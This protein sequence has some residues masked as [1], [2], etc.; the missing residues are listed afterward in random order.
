MVFEKICPQQ[1]QRLIILCGGFHFSAFKWIHKLFLNPNE[2][3]WEKNTVLKRHS[4]LLSLHGGSLA[5]KKKAKNMIED[6][7]FKAI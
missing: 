4:A 3:M 6:W 7:V 5:F 2:S 1:K